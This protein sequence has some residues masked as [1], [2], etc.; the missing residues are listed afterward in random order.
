MTTVLPFGNNVI[1]VFSYEKFDFTISNPSPVS[2]TLSLLSNTSGLNPTSFYFTGDGGTS[3][4]FSLTDLQNKLTSSRV[5]EQFV[6]GLPPSSSTSTNQVFINPGRFLD[7]NGST[8]S[9]RSFTFFKSEPI[10]KIR[11]VA[12]S[13]SLKPLISIPSLPP[14]LS[15]VSVA[16]NIVDISG[17]PLVTLPTNNYQIIG[18]EQGGSK[19]I[20]TRVNLSVSNERINLNVANPV[21][22]GM[23][24]GTSI[25]P[26][27]LTA[28]PPSGTSVLR[29]TFPALPDGITVT[30]ISGVVR[31]SPFFPTDPSYTLIVSGTP[32]LAAANAFRDASATSNGFVYDIRATRTVPLPLVESTQPFQFAFGE[33]VLFDAFLIPPLFVGVPLSNISFSAKTHF[34]SN[35]PISDIFSIGLRNDLS[36]LFNPSTSIAQLTGTPTTPGPINFTIRAVN[37]NGIL[38]DSLG[39]TVVSEDVV[40]FNTPVGTDL[41]FS[42][43][44]SRPVDQLI[45]FTAVSSS[46]RSVSLSAP[47]LLGTGLSLDSTGLLIGT[48]TEVRPLSNLNVIATVSGSPATA[49]KTVRFE[50]LNDVFTFADIPTERLSFVENIPSTPFQFPVSTL[51][52]RNVVN[53]SQTGLPSGLTI[54]PGGVLSGIP[55]SSTPTSGTLRV[56]ATTGFA[57]G[58]RDFNFS[59]IPDSILFVVNPTTYS[60]QAGAP[61]DTIDIDAL[62]FSG[63]SIS[64]YDLSMG[65]TYGMNMNS[66]NGVI[67]GTWASGLPPGD[68]YS[69]SCNFSVRATAGRLTG[70]L[71]ATLSANPIV[72]NAMLFVGYG[73]PS[74][75]TG[76]KSYLYSTTPTGVSSFTRVGNGSSTSRISDIQIKN[77]DPTNNVVLASTIGGVLRGTHLNNMTFLSFDNTSESIIALSSIVNTGTSNWRVGGRNI[78]SDVSAGAAVLFPSS[79]DG[80]TWDTSDVL[81]VKNSSGQ[82]LHTRDDGSNAYDTNAYLSGGVALKYNSASGVLMAGGLYNGEDG[83][84]MLRSTDDGSNW[85]DVTGGFGQ[86]CAYFSLD[87]SDM[88]IATGSDDFQSKNFV[89]G[90]SSFNFIA[91]NTIKYS[92]NQGSNWLDATNGFQMFGYEVVYGNGSWLASGVSVASNTAAGSGPFFIPQLKFSENGSNWSNVVLDPDTN[93]FSTSNTTPLVAPLR[94]GSLNFD[95]NFWNVFVNAEGSSAQE[96]LRLFRHTAT[97]SLAS[98][99]TSVSIASSLVT[100]EPQVNQFLRYLALTPPKFLFTG[101]PPINISLNFEISGGQGPTITG[102]VSRSFL[103]YQYVSISPITL[104]ATNQSGGQI[105]FFIAAEEL[106]PGLT[107]NP[108]TREITGRPAQAGRVETRVYAKDD[109]GV[110]ISTLLFNT[111]V[112]RVIRRQDGAGAYTSLLRQYTDVL[113]AQNARDNRVLPNQ[114]RAL[115][116]FMSPEAPD[117]ITQVIDPKCRNPNC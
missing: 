47:D 46:G 26:R 105:Y 99:W 15:F 86:E 72:E 64:R 65:F 55:L 91:T 23:N 102:P 76:L 7:S 57:S 113:G 62:A 67:S 36:V 59:L 88:W 45:R 75:E 96:V 49:T 50:I 34:T 111:V 43:I 73:N 70:V 24:V 107:F 117:V 81:F 2:N 35:V 61:I 16:S 77:N 54:D 114:E 69:A 17:T 25:T 108:L 84:V 41:S 31:T 74:G 110:S 51:S 20:T 83:P 40:T 10:D 1:Q 13:F 12:P 100:G 85:N 104:T 94:L 21:I 5:P 44:L 27:I 9:N 79:D 63:A 116:E 90:S 82:R 33:T 48:P 6:L 66:G 98:G 14:G 97:G 93:L 38:R 80:N 87:E 92:T 18:V 115:G 112:P 58:F 39:S 109:N 4:R 95:G 71:P 101:E 78:R 52:G 106:P 53:F 68:L 11:L 30:D 56:T 103:Q 37:S 22:G 60:F 29:Y 89:G 3:I 28:I 8:L 19:V 32:T 42:F